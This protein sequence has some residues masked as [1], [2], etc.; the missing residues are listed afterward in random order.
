MSRGHPLSSKTGSQKAK[1]SIAR[2]RGEDTDSEEITD[3]IGDALDDPAGSIGPS[4]SKPT[5]SLLRKSTKWVPKK[6]SEDY[7]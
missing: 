4:S 5:S 7:D 3:E 6:E 1:P 2:R